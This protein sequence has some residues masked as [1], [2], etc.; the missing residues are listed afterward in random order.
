VAHHQC[1]ASDRHLALF[2]I[3]QEKKE[4]KKKIDQYSQLAQVLVSSREGGE[5]ML[6]GMREGKK[7]F[8]NEM[9]NVRKKQHNGAMVRTHSWARA[10]CSSGWML[11][12]A[13][14]EGCSNRAQGRGIK[15]KESRE[16]HTA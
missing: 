12:Q 14:E 6:R 1:S 4:K 16:A 5:E 10:F 7:V 13:R 15:R 9:R 11:Q 2:N 3:F 8:S